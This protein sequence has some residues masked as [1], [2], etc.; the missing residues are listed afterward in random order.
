ML[1]SVYGGGLMRKFPGNARLGLTL[2][3]TSPSLN[4]IISTE[5]DASPDDDRELAM[6]PEGIAELT[7]R[8]CVA[9][10][11]SRGVNDFRPA[12]REEVLACS[13]RRRDSVVQR[14]AAA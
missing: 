2:F 14:R 4:R 11:R 5:V 9:L 7:R 10:N 3:F 13:I 1:A 12:T 6:L 8:W